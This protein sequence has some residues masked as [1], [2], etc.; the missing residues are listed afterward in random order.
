MISL[1]EM[2]KILR[3]AH[4]RPWLLPKSQVPNWLVRL[5]GPFF[6]LS[7]DYTRKHLGIRFKIDNTRS[8]EELG[9]VYRPIGQTLIDHY[10]SWIEQKRGRT[11]SD[12]LRPRFSAYRSSDSGGA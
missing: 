1:V 12:A 6:G 5:F 11:S 2:S 10:N 4:K 8:I 9:I 7:R 3:K